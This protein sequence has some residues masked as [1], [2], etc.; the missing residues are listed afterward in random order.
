MDYRLEQTREEHVDG[1][2]A[3]QR[4]CFPEPFPAE[5]LWKPDHIQ[6]H[7]EIFAPGQYVILTRDGEVVGSCTN[8]LT[9]TTE[10]NSHRPW[11]NAVGGLDLPRHDPDGSIVY[12]IDI[13]VH[14]AHRRRG[15]AKRFY[16]AR[17]DLVRA[18]GLALYGTVCRMPGYATSDAASPTAYAESVV[19]R[20]RTD[21]TLTPLLR[22]G[23]EYK[24]CIDAYMDDEESGNA[25]AILEWTP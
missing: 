14:P 4:A 5:L 18:T 16:Q 2:V 7:I 24:G 11:D 3:L 15:L 13:S 12:G 21:P 6:R 25:G 19:D 20:Q 22:T 17:F 9:S 8:M 1:V 23:L 10:W